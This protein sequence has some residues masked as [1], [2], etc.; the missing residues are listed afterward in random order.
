M[1]SD[2]KSVDY[3]RKSGGYKRFADKKSIFILHP[4]GE[5]QLYSIKRNIFDFQKVQ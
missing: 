2:N 5:S 3:F 1:Y 4:N